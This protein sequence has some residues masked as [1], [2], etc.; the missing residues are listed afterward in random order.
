MP[1][2]IRLLEWRPRALWRI[3]AAPSVPNVFRTML[4]PVAVGDVVA[5]RQTLCVIDAMKMQN[6]IAADGPGVVTAVHVTKGATVS[7]GSPLVDLAEPE[8]E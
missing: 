7:A 6:P 5:E 3:A 1:G 8:Q 2:V 4:P